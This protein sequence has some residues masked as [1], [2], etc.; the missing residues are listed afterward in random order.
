MSK[1]LKRLHTD[2][3]NFMKLMKLMKAEVEN[4]TTNGELYVSLILDIVDYI[5]HYPNTIHHPMENVIFE[6]YLQK[7]DSDCQPIIQLLEEHNSLSYI[8]VKIEECMQKIKSGEIQS[9]D[10]L[11]EK[12]EQFIS[13]QIEHINKEEKEVF[14][15]LENSFTKN[16]WKYIDSKLTASE[17]PLFGDKMK[18]GYETLYKRISDSA[19]N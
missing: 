1:A 5:Q 11:I 9:K 12:L 19:S 8:P 16:D 7:Y 15:L 17:D 13:D 18:Q 2:H 14:P 10:A 3:I 6:Y 4:I